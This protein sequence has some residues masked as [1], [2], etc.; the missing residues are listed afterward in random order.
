[1]LKLSLFEG[2]QKT[3]HFVPGPLNANELLRR[4]GFQELSSCD[5][6]TQTH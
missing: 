3:Q 6:L 2:L 1:M 4:A 5:F